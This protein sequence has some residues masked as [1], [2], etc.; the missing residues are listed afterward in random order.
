MAPR[1]SKSSP[2]FSI[3]RKWWQITGGIVAG[4][5]EAGRGPW[6]GPVAAAAVILDPENLPIGIDDSK[7]LNTARRESIYQKIIDT[8][9]VGVALAK[10]HHIDKLNILGATLWT[11][12]MAFSNLA[13]TPDAVLIDGDQRPDINCPMETIIKGDAKSLSIA[14]ASIIAK[15]T[16]DRVMINLDHKYPEYGWIRNKGYGTREHAH[17]IAK[18]GVTPHHRKSF[19]PIKRALEAQ[20][21]V[22]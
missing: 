2:D 15:V 6:A 14:A 20:N 1:D 11:M 16:R 19:A 5:D 10:P 7:K 18:F 22:L 8:S 13:E 9:I 3:E 4:I 21:L 17:A 12:Q